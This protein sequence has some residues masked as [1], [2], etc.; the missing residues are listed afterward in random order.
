MTRD[1][2]VEFIRTA[3]LERFV[4]GGYD[5]KAFLERLA[6]LL[7]GLMKASCDVIAMTEAV[8]KCTLLSFDKEKLVN[9]CTKILESSESKPL[10]V[11]M[12]NSDSPVQQMIDKI[13]RGENVFSDDSSGP[14]RD[15]SS[16]R[17]IPD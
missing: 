12:N 15:E 14:I 16:R 13:K 3:I 5:T 9:I 6:I 17:D 2:K 10:L 7:E 1:E 8:S 11:Q 4:P